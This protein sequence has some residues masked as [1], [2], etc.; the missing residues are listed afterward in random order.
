MTMQ[1][2]TVNLPEIYIDAIGKLTG[3]GMFP[4]RS[5]AIRAALRDFLKN[6]L[7]MVE[8]LLDLNEM[9]GTVAVVPGPAIPK[10][11]KL[12]MRSCK[13]GW[14][15]NT[16]PVSNTKFGSVRGVLTT[17]DVARSVPNISDA[18]ISSIKKQLGMK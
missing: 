18:S 2:V 9:D 1:I 17:G 15:E 12:D 10:Q 14:A 11:R 16:K 4:S 7:E 6:E 5:E 3:Q 13:A 8:S